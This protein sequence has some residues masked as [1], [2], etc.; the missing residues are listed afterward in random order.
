LAA[1]VAASSL[2]SVLILPLLHFIRAPD[3]DEGLS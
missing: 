2:S 3:T 1:V